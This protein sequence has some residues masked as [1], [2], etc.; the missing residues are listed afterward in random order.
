MA[1]NP[2]PNPPSGGNDKWLSSATL[3]AIIGMGLAF[4]AIMVLAFRLTSPAASDIATMVTV[5]TTLVGTL[6]GYIVG[7][8]G[9]TKSDNRAARAEQNA[10]KGEALASLANQLAK[11]HKPK[12]AGVAPAPGSAEADLQTLADVGKEIL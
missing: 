2:N 7:S 5:F 8:E 9:K 3:I 11:Q 12:A 4:I 6:A 1:V 10:A